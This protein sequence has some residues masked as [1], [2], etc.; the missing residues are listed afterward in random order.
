M[1]DLKALATLKIHEKPET[2]LTTKNRLEKL[3]AVFIF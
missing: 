2:N 3:K 1:S